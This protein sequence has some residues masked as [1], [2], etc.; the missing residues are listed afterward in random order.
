MS[1][2]KR[3]VICI[4]RQFGSGGLEVAKKLSKELGIPCY[5]KEV[6]DEALAD[7][8]LPKDIL[9]AASEHKANPFLHTAYKQIASVRTFFGML[10]SIHS[11][12]S[13]KVL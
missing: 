5:D 1:T 2:T 9:R 8:D 3:K 11:V 12:L 4:G 7:T 13:S 10:A 6:L